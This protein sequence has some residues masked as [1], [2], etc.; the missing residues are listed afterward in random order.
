M[1]YGDC[2]KKY[3]VIGSFTT[4]ASDPATASWDLRPYQ[5]AGL[6]T[7]GGRWRLIEVGYNLL[8][9]EGKISA[10]GTLVSSDYVEPSTPMRSGTPSGIPDRHE[11]HYSYPGYMELQV[12]DPDP[13]CK[14]CPCPE[15]EKEEKCKCPQ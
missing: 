3:R 4:N 6:G 2:K 13:E 12:T 8:Y 11:S 9:A 5:T 14:T 7:P 15:D 10:D 1:T